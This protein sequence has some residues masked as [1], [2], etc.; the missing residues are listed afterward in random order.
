M[1]TRGTPGRRRYRGAVFATIRIAII[2]WSVG[3][4]RLESYFRY[5]AG[6]AGGGGKK[7]SDREIIPPRREGVL[8]ARLPLLP[9]LLT[10]LETMKLEKNH[11][12]AKFTLELRG[13]PTLPYIGPTSGLREGGPT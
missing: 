12:G 10:G 3:E 7:K 8:P 4:G 13:G 1:T 2:T 9:T 11:N 5:R 6:G